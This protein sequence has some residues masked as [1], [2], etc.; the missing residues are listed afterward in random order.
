MNHWGQALPLE[1]AITPVSMAKPSQIIMKISNC[2][3][4]Y[5]DLTFALGIP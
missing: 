1:F 3:L 4:R 5:A 2:V